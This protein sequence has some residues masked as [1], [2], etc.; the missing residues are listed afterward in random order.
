MQQRLE[1]RLKALRAL[2]AGDNRGQKHLALAGPLL[3]VQV[4]D[5]DADGPDLVLLLLEGLNA[6]QAN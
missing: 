3:R 1:I 2:R 6:V 4:P 5:F